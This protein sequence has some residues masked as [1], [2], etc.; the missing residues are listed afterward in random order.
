MLFLVIKANVATFQYEIWAIM[1]DLVNVAIYFGGFL[2]VLVT[3]YVIYKYF[4]GPNA[5]E[6]LL[7]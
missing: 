6:L 2:S 1:L 5:F 3:Y 4:Y 7:A